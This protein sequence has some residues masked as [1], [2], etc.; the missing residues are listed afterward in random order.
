SRPRSASAL[1][2]PHHPRGA[3]SGRAALPVAG[4]DG[5]PGAGGRRDDRDSRWRSPAVAAR[6]YRADLP[7]RRT[8]LLKFRKDRREAG[9]V[10]GIGEV[11]AE[12]R[13]EAPVVDPL[14]LLVEAAGH[15]AQIGILKGDLRR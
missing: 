1:S 13:L 14:V 15:R 10:V 12:P 7:D 8:L 2:R 4:A 11:N 5:E 6:R 3:R 9:P